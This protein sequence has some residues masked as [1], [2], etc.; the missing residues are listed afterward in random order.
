MNKKGFSLVELM[1]V[2]VILVV[3]T[4][5]ATSGYRLVMERIKKNSYENKVSYLETKAVE[6]ANQTGKL[7]M[8]V[9]QLVK[10]G[11][12]QADNEKGEV[13]SPIDGSL[14]NCHLIYIT[15]E[16]NQLY[17]NY[18]EQE[19]CDIEKIQTE[20][21]F[22]KISAYKTL[23]N[24]TLGE[25][26][27]EKE[28]TKENVILV[29]EFLDSNIL[30]E[31]IK[32]ITWR[33][34]AKEETVEVENNFDSK[35][36]YLVTAEQIV[37]SIYTVEIKMEDGTLYQT[38]TY[39]R[40]DKQRPIVYDKEIRVEKENEY[41]ASEKEVHVEA[42]DGNGSGIYGYYIGEENRCNEVVYEESESTHYSKKMGM[43]TFYIC[44]KD[45]AGNV[46]EDISTK[47]VEVK[48]IDSEPPMIKV[49]KNPLTLGTEDY[50][51]KNNLEVVWGESGEGSISCNPTISKK[52]GIY[53][54]ICTVI[55]KNGLEKE[56]SFE[57][58]HSYPATYVS[59]TCVREYDCHEY[60]YCPCGNNHCG[61]NGPN[62]GHD[63]CYP[64]AMGCC[65]NC[66]EITGV[67]CKKE[68]YE[69][70]NYTCPQGGNPINGICY[71]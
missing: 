65:D 51:F 71:Y 29:A 31:K 70:G 5:L 23:D 61:D 46:S 34:N 48:Y 30:L 45:K 15:E 59:K 49:K 19:E 68:N 17:G 36:K 6:Y 10:S 69:C 33:S 44:V 3:I 20:N 27:E 11:T 55:G 57:V 37:N 24:T 38:E 43:G 9:D 26:V 41:T 4:L 13:I 14:M 1:G 56:V 28:W 63:G 42:S 21:R 50:E 32:S 16:N 39:V 12:I 7:Q 67:S 47:R 54:V 25:K 64:D 35:N 60:K 53:E 18:T 62:C 22:L 52:T 40:I 58:R 8:N 2:L 66:N